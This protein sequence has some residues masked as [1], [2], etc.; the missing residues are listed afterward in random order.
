M[1]KLQVGDRV[2]AK[3]SYDWLSTVPPGAGTVVAITEPGSVEVDFDDWDGGWARDWEDKS[4]RSHWF[5]QEDSLEPVAPRFAVG[6]RVCVKAPARFVVID[7]SLVECGR[8][9]SSRDEAESAATQLVDSHSGE[10][11]VAQIFSKASHEIKLE[12]VA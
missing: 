4:P 5:L 6:D 11:L 9:F 10:F 1:S 3:A 2:R 7:P 8:E 12:R